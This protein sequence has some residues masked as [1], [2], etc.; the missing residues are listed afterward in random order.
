MNIEE[1]IAE[2]EKRFYLIP[3]QKES[4][5]NDWGNL[6]NTVM[7]EVSRSYNLTV[8]ELK[9]RSRKGTIPEAKHMVTYIVRFVNPEV[10]EAYLAKE[11][12]H[13][14]HTSCIHSI[15]YI[16]GLLQVDNQMKLTVNRI[17]H[18]IKNTKEKS[19]KKYLLV[20]KLGVT[21]GEF[22]KLTDIAKHL[23]SNRHSTAKVLDR[24]DRTI[25]GYYVKTSN[26]LITQ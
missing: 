19:T 2:L 8:N 17:V 15:K 5:Y 26:N 24:P 20:N 10:T 13:K 4:E 1:V 12:G 21:C 25:Y 6:I 11:L 7:F 18:K 9:S 14:N 22:F 16:S 3:K 23:G